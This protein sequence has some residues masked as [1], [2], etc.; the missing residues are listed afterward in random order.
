MII[1]DSVVKI[2][3]S[4]FDKDVKLKTIIFKKIKNR[5]CCLCTNETQQKKKHQEKHLIRQ[6]EITKI[7][8]NTQESNTERKE[9]KIQTKIFY[10]KNWKRDILIHLFLKFTTSNKK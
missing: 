9:A 5:W 2:G 7:R 10:A 4:A 6:A 8:A 3:A 1:P